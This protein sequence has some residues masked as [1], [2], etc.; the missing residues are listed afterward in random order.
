MDRPWYNYAAD[1]PMSNP[2]NWASYDEGATWQ[3]LGDTS[4]G[5]SASPSYN[6]DA[7]EPYGTSSYA[8]DNSGATLQ[9]QSSYGPPVNSSELGTTYTP[10][11]STP[12]GG[13]SNPAKEG[14]VPPSSGDYF[15]LPGAQAPASGSAP[16][17]ATGYGGGASDFMSP[18]ATGVYGLGTGSSLPVAPAT[19]PLPNAAG[20][21][22]YGSGGNSGF[23][24]GTGGGGGY[25]TS[26]G[27]T[28]PPASPFAAAQ[29][30]GMMLPGGQMFGAPKQMAPD[31]SFDPFLW[32]GTAN[33]MP[34]PSP[35]RTEILGELGLLPNQPQQSFNPM[36]PLRYVESKL[37]IGSSGA[38]A[39]PEPPMPPQGMPP[40]SLPVAPVGGIPNLPPPILP[41]TRRRF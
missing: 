40:A 9:S 15:T 17:A 35:M 12:A 28:N 27:Y 39:M 26:G 19:A 20:T 16:G 8:V 41:G 36:P 1:D 6:Y 10:P 14:Y 34:A 11:P 25:D 5:A 21:P 7:A 4:G 22:Q 23:V 31:G 37:G 32:S 3:Y 2:Y 18:V 38:P 24:A 30:G 29:S 13:Y 33:P